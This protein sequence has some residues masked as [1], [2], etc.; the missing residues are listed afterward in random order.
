MMH[1]LLSISGYTFWLS[2]KET[3]MLVIRKFVAPMAMLLVILAFVS[4][5]DAWMHFDAYM[6]SPN[7]SGP[8]LRAYYFLVRIES[9]LA[10]IGG[11]IA[12]LVG[13]MLILVTSAGIDQRR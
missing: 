4:Y 2:F 7:S 5:G 10:T 12:A 11:T 3:S 13:A 6:A 1:F 8:Q 9:E